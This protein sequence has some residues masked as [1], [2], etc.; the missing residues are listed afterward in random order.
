MLKIHFVKEEMAYDGSQLS[1]L[2]ALR[3]FGIQGD[4]LVVFKGPMD[5]KTDH[6]ADMEDL[7]QGARIRSSAMLH[8]LVEFFD[9]DLERVILRQR[10]MVRLAADILSDTWNAGVSV[11]GDDLYI[12]EK[13]LSVSIAAPSPVSCLIHLGLNID[14]KGVPVKAA[15]L[16]E[17]GVDPDIL[18]SSL[19]RS[20]AEELDAIRRAR[21]KVR[22]VP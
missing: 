2:F 5:V 17:L 19:A 21:C 14:T 4:S 9:A 18:G 1:S 6:M 7:L 13:K 3:K 10:L 20:F 22:A 8:F 11:V 16:K 15:S 12:E